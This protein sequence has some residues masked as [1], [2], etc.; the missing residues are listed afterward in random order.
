MDFFG[1]FVI[2]IV[3][4]DTKGELIFEYVGNFHRP[5]NFFVD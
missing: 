2:T 1:G 5:K 3:I 4:A